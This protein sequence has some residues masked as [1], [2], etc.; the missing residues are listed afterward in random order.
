M[1]WLGLS[2]LFSSILYVIFKLFTRFKVNTLQA[3]VVNYAVATC[4]GIYMSDN[5]VNLNEIKE[6]AWLPW[7]LFMGL[8]FISIF[9]IMALTAQ[10]NGL[11]VAAVAGKMSLVIPVTIGFVAYNETAGWIKI[12]GI[13]I[14]LLAVYFTTTRNYGLVSKPFEIKNLLFPG[15]LFL[16]SGVIDSILKHIE[17]NFMK[18]EL[19]ATI[20]ATIFC[21]AFLAGLTILVRN[22]FT[23]GT[24]FEFKSI[25]AG[26]VLG[27]PNYF[28]IIFIFKALA[29]NDEASF[30]YPVN[31]VGTILLSTMLG[32][33]LFKERLQ[34]RNWIGILLAVGAISLIAFAKA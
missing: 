6:A 8:L 28:S 19:E 21:T 17:I 16:G 31:H 27:I 26:M 5:P 33:L 29:A 4:T 30:V 15:I 22:Y 23:Q 25:L 24:R 10:R 12:L 32:L 14:A 7:A 20:S 34:V 3:I 18:P 11:S 13:C 1:I 9:N 2:I